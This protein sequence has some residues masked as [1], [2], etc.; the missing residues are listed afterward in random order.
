MR[1]SGNF[2]SFVRNKGTNLIM[3]FGQ[4]QREL[5]HNKD[6]AENQ[7]KTWWMRK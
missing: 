5:F 1:K 2:A 6:G 3:P 7:K 4:S